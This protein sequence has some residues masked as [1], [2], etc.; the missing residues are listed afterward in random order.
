[1]TSSGLPADSPQQ[2]R[3]G[4]THTHTHTLTH[5]LDKSSLCTEQH[6]VLKESTWASPLFKSFVPSIMLSDSGDSSVSI[7]TGLAFV[8]Y[9]VSVTVCTI[10]GSTVAGLKT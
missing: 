9:M 10:R 8:Q 7:K 2:E 5:R 6:E 3:E 1:M 4:V